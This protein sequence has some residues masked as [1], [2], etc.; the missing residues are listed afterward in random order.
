VIENPAYICEHHFEKKFIRTGSGFK[1]LHPEAVPRIFKESGRKVN[2]T[3]QSV[4]LAPPKLRTS[5]LKLSITLFQLQ[6]SK[7]CGKR[8]KCPDH[9]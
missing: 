9:K 5:F 2:L 4:F 7:T 6:I 8:L 3:N 1:R